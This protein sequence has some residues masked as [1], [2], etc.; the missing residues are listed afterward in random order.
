M[1][2]SRQGFSLLEVILALAI[3][4]GVVAV[5]GELVRS[6]L[7]STRDARDTTYAELLCESIMAEMAAKIRTPE[8]VQE[9]PCSDLIEGS[10]TDQS[11]WLY[12][13]EVNPAIEEGLLELRLRVYADLPDDPNPPE[14]MMVR[15]MPDPDYLAALQAATEE[16]RA[17]QNTSSSSGNTSSSSSGSDSSGSSSSRSSSSGSGS[18]SG[19][20]TAVPIGGTPMPGPGMS[21]SGSGSPGRGSGTSGR[22]SGS[23][24]RGSGASGPGSGSTGPGPSRGGGGARG[25]SRG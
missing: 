2:S 1:K 7:R 13:L 23:S 6:G 25:G 19:S 9:A 11:R 4:A 15:W 8:S 14:C 21:G 20:G 5:I 18:T 10:P 3:L 12:S 17:A 24:G 22:G 16:M